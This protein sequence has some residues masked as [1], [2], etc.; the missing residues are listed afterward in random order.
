M[1]EGELFWVLG[2]RQEVRVVRLDIFDKKSEENERRSCE[3][4]KDR[5]HMKIVNLL[6]ERLRERLKEEKKKE[7]KYKIVWL[8]MESLREM[9]E[10]G[11]REGK[12]NVRL[13]GCPRENY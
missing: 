1:R 2:K 9:G 13:L 10:R 12:K 7:R 4:K 6:M 8:F 3:R 5:G 11:K